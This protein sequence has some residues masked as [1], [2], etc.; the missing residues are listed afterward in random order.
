M[1]VT[2]GPKEPQHVLSASVKGTHLPLALLPRDSAGTRK[3]APRE[4]RGLGPEAGTA[5]TALTS[6][7]EASTDF[8]LR[9][10]LSVS[11]ALLYLLQMSS[12]E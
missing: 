1:A 6:D 12:S 9:F 10:V 8:S 2:S 7:S 3:A 11:T 5:A 4:G